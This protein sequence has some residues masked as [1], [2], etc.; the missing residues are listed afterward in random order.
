MDF[1]LVQCS[2][3]VLETKLIPVGRVADALY[4]AAQQVLNTTRCRILH[5]H[6]CPVAVVQR[7]LAESPCCVMD[8]TNNCPAGKHWSAKWKHWFSSVWARDDANTWFR[9]S[10]P[11]MI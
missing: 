11:L 8:H 9:T 5:V 1:H 10:S 4:P 7:D 2:S 6:H 3:L